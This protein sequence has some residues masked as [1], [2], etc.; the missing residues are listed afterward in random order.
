MAANR[1][2][3]VARGKT[4]GTPGSVVLAKTQTGVSLTFRWFPAD[5]TALLEKTKVCGDSKTLKAL[6]F[7]VGKL[8]GQTFEPFEP[9]SKRL[10]DAA[11]VV[12]RLENKVFLAADKSQQLKYRE[13]AK[14]AATHKKKPPTDDAGKKKLAE[15]AALVAQGWVD[16]AVHQLTLLH[17]PVGTTIATCIAGDSKPKFR[18]HPLW[19]IKLG[20]KNSVLDIFETYG[21]KALEDKAGEMITR[22]QGAA[23]QPGS[24]NY[25]PG[26]LTGDIWL[27]SS[28]P[29]T[30]ADV[31]AL[32]LDQ[33]TPA[34][35]AAL[36]KIYT[37]QLD[38]QGKDF[39]LDVPK[40]A[41]GTT[42][43]RL[44]WL[45][46]E[47]TNCQHNI[48]RVDL[49]T[50][51]PVR[52]HPAAYA[53][54]ARAAFDAK[55]QRIDISSSW[56]PML[57]AIVHRTGRGLDVKWLRGEKTLQLNR[58]DLGKEKGTATVSQEEQD[59]FRAMKAAEKA[60]SEAIKNGKATEIRAAR[61]ANTTATTKWT[62]AVEKNQ[63]AMIDSFRNSL[64]SA[65]P[66]VT[67]L[68]DPWYMES[69][70]QDSQAP[71][72]NEQKDGNEKLHR[73]HLHITI[74]DPELTS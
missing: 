16:V 66:L 58:S 10:P 63:P 15:W 69:S 52:V 34:M 17:L 47:N 35:K 25:Y 41:T 6:P 1:S 22:P 55:I 61:D 73:H 57:G 28:H 68:F 18:R 11:N 29:F 56:R 36:K 26:R 49:R 44:Y 74:Q 14:Y 43:I 24:T 31:D 9:K 7:I 53:A 32:T 48:S 8:T 3:V 60:L 50:D 21:Q 40:D 27:R 19:P 72:P 38:R 64:L 45:A 23:G 37:G 59:A 12:G 71:V 4:N 51:V 2:G 42:K 30:V 13:L 65:K 33:V 5:S 46:S 62:R 39:W 20:D 67:Q 54:A 70:P